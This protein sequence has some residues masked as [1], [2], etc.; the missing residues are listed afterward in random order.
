M[1]LFFEPKEAMSFRL[2]CKKF[3]CL[4]PV[5]KKPDMLQSLADSIFRESGLYYFLS[6]PFSFLLLSSFLI[7]PSSLPFPFLLPPSLL[8]LLPSL[9][10]SSS[11]SLPL[12]LP[13]PPPS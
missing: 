4:K 12:P 5:E 2:T 13:L 1:R 3:A 7:P 10:S 9:P 6:S 11:F 8:P